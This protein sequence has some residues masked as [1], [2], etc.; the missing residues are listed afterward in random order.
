MRVIVSRRIDHNGKIEEKTV[1]AE[2]EELFSEVRSEEQRALEM[3]RA[4]FGSMDPPLRVVEQTAFSKPCDH[5]EDKMKE[6]M[7][8]PVKHEEDLA[9]SYVLPKEG[10]YIM[11]NGVKHTVRNAVFH[12]GTIL[13]FPSVTIALERNS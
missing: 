4:L 13:D 8:D 11:L 12:P 6:R 3:A 1:E 7:V 5:A 10:S 2:V 9:V